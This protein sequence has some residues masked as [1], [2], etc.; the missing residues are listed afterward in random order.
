MTGDTGANAEAS[1]W[2]VYIVRCAD[3]TLYTGVTVDID[4]RLAAHNAGAGARYTR[5]RLPVDLVY[6]EPAT[7][8]AAAQRR[9]W[10]IKQMTA[11]AK[12]R[13]ISVSDSP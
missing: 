8:R 9:E 12:R 11:V 3:N 7:D 4:A 5:A 1:G 10:Q 6:R 13:L 2:C